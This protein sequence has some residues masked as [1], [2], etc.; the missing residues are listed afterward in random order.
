MRQWE[1]EFILFRSQS[2]LALLVVSDGIRYQRD[3]FITE[4]RDDLVFA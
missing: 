2:S 1:N 4:P 3:Y